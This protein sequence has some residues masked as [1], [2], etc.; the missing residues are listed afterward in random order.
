MGTELD[1][2]VRTLFINTPTDPTLGADVWVHTQIARCL[3]RRT[4]AV[5]IAFSPGAPGHPTPLEREIQGIPE[6]SRFALDP[7]PLPPR[8]PLDRLRAPAGSRIIALAGQPRRVGPLR[9]HEQDRC[10]PH[11]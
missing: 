3:D 7:G 6:L 11:V 5:H 9:P 4:H 1:S 8:R 2:C 10:S